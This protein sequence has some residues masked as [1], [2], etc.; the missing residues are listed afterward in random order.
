MYRE[1]QAE[2]SAIL[3]R[4]VLTHASLTINNKVM[5]QND[6]LKLGTTNDNTLN[7]LIHS[8]ML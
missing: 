4:R 3:E 5:C 1:S 6:D 7:K 2:Q 8:S